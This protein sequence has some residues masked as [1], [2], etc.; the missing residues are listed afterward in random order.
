MK[1]LNGIISVLLGIT[2][3][4]LMFIRAKTDQDFIIG[5]TALMSS[6]V[7]MCF[8][9][10]EERKE[11]VERLRHTILRMKGHEVGYGDESP[12]EYKRMLKQVGK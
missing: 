12:A 11:E 10:L 1:M 9:L 2:A 5:F 6:I 7:F 4:Y 8:M 3:L